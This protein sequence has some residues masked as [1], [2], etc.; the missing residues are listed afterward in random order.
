V[1][2]L[3]VVYTVDKTTALAGE[4]RNIGQALSN[5]TPAVDDIEVVEVVVPVAKIGL[6]KKAEPIIPDFDAQT[7]IINY[8]LEF[9]NVGNLPLSNIKAT[10]NLDITFGSSI[11]KVEAI[12]SDTFS[13]NQGYNGSSDISLFTQPAQANALVPGQKAT[14]TLTV[15]IPF[16]AIT[17]ESFFSNIAEVQAQS[18]LGDPVGDTSSGKKDSDVD[19]DGDGDPTNNSEPTEIR[20]IPMDDPTPINIRIDKQVPQKVYIIGEVVPYTV[21]VASDS[22]FESITTDIID[23]LPFGTTYVPDTATIALAG[24]ALDIPVVYENDKLTWPNVTI[25]PT[26]SVE[27]GYSLRIGPNVTDNLDNIV[28]AIGEG[29]SGRV[30]AKVQANASITISRDLFD[31]S[32]NII[33][34]RIYLDVNNNNVYDPTIDLGIENAR[35]ILGNGTQ[36]R[37]DI[38]GNY[39]FR[40]VPQGEAIVQ[41]DAASVFFKPRQTN[42]S[43]NNGYTHRIRVAGLTVSDFPLIP[44]DGAGATARDTTVVLGPVT[45]D[46]HHEQ[47]ADGSVKVVLNLFS[48]EALDRPIVITDAIPQSEP[49]T[50]VR[51]IYAG[52]QETV[53]YFVP[54]GTPLTDP[55]IEF[56][57][58]GNVMQNLIVPT[59]PVEPVVVQQVVEAVQP[60]PQP[61]A[62]P[63]NVT[64][65]VTPTATQLDVSSLN[66]QAA[67][68][69]EFGVL[70][71]N[72]YLVTNN[73]QSEV[74]LELVSVG[75]LP[76]PVRVTDVVSNG[77]AQVFDRDIVDGFY[78]VI[79]FPVAQGTNISDPVLS[80]ALE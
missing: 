5:E 27:I 34:G 69:V 41:L 3:D 56:Q 71:V 79:R 64:P 50:M 80:W 30:T 70:T 23:S 8:V 36:A 21:S 24:N 31:L 1:I 55:T 29:T 14:V 73:G 62:S 13:V 15:T 54:A 18:P 47:M 11:Y 42:E 32:E 48:R 20:L 10:D 63:V 16:S 57:E 74:V 45:L 46:K 37:T 72:K 61:V 2:A 25:P 53:E 75:E 17:T 78:E 59:E 12:S 49:F 65:V 43:S 9:V 67:T 68:T 76:Y 38:E 58:A 35:L 7:F 22:E 19:P 40:D 51:N 33:T 28:E 4:V 6:A 77:Q 26:Q 66:I 39:S 60:V 52:Y 44:V